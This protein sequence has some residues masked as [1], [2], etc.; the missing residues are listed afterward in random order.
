MWSQRILNDLKLLTN[1][2]DRIRSEMEVLQIYS[3]SSNK[4]S[5]YT[6]SKLLL[7]YENTNTRQHHCS[8]SVPLHNTSSMSLRC[9]CTTVHCL[10]KT[11][12]WVSEAPVSLS[13]SGLS[14]PLCLQAGGHGPPPGDEQPSA[15]PQANLSTTASKDFVEQRISA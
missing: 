15:A 4:D 5:G 2:S 11:Y 13:L 3:Q 9:P 8:C 10:L 14:G 12:L 6:S 7:L 1:K